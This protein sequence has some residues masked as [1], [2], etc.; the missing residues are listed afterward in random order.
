LT[1]PAATIIL[2]LSCA[3]VGAAALLAVAAA[4][5]VAA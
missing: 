5:W 1:D 2:A 3:C 4:I